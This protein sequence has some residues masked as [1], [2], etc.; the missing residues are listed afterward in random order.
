MV[1]ED[2]IAA[3]TRDRATIGQGADGAAAYVVDTNVTQPFN[4]ACISQGG[5]RATVVVDTVVVDTAS[6]T[7]DRAAVCQGADRAS[8]VDT[9]TPT[10]DR[11]TVC[12]GGDGA[13]VVPDTIEASTRDRA[14]VS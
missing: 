13:C 10:R 12:Q 14:T 3:S 8:V 7:R 4:G 1:V 2:T 5:D 11:A 6:V 9:S